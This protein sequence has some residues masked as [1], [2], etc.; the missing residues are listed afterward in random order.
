MAPPPETA[1]T[2]PATKG[3]KRWARPLIAAVAYAA[4]L[5]LA[6]RAID[7]EKFVEGLKRLRVEHL[8]AILVVALVHVAGRAL[9]FHWLMLRAKPTSEYHWIDGFRIFLVGLSTSAVTPAR[10]GDFVKAQLVRPYGIGGNVGIGLVMVERMLDLLVITASIILTGTLVSE[11]S[12][13]HAWQAG[14]WVLLACLIAGLVVVG[15]KALRHR[16]F[17]LLGTLV[18]KVK[19]GSDG[20][21]VQ[22]LLHGVFQVWDTVFS[23]LPSF[24]GYAAYSAVVWSIEFMKLWLVLHFL[25]AAVDP[26]TVLFVYPVS[27]VAG[28]LTV[29]PFSEGVVGVTGV[30]L[31][32]SIAG[33]DSAMA[34]IAV[35]LDRAASSLPPMLLWGLFHAFGRRDTPAAT[36]KADLPS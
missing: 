35:V 21:R 14:A 23:S 20:A 17:A 31:L 26:A 28:I 8:L 19:R 25:G 9:R 2:A 29:L 34:T 4:I 24:L 36:S 16:V 18:A 13:S 22:E 27:I 7:H 1:T 10:A 33:V 15:V 6:W 5:G 3:A 12:G 11:R 30:A 32:G